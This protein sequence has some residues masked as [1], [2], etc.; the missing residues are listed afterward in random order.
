MAAASALALG[1]G[2]EPFTVK[3]VVK[4]ATVTVTTARGHT[5]CRSHG[6][7]HRHASPHA[8]ARGVFL[9]ET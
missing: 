9:T 5:R 2:I 6:D 1:H 4:A 8:L 3:I 7:G